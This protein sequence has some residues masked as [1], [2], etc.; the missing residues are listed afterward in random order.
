M[1]NT[2]LAEKGQFLREGTIV[3][4]ML[5]A[6]V[7]STKN[8]DGKREENLELPV[9]WHVAMRPRKRK[10]LSKTTEGGLLEKIEHT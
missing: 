4:D 7:P 1:I 8:K 9:I 5:I 10:A 3:D 6:A 2:H